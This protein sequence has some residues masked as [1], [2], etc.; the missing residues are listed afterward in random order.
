MVRIALGEEINIVYKD[1]ILTN[2]GIKGK[3]IIHELTNFEIKVMK[4]FFEN[5]AIPIS[6]QTL[7]EKVWMDKST[8]DHA[9][10][11][12]MT[13]IIDRLYDDGYLMEFDKKE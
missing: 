2:K 4:Y 8:T 11:K 12:K 10:R 9:I 13:D 5:P 6:H 7:V 3:G 1:F